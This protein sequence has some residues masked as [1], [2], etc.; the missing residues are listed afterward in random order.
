M[1]IWLER[2]R[3]RMITMVV[4]ADDGM[5]M[6]EGVSRVDEARMRENVLPVEG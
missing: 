3:R 6:M 4:D 2:R 1:W 5:M